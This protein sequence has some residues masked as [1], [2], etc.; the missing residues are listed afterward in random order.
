MIKQ[1][2][3]IRELIS[4]APAEVKSRAKEYRP[5]FVRSS[6]NT[7]VY[8]VGDYTV[9][10]KF[11]KIQPRLRQQLTQVQYDKLRKIKDRDT[12]VSCTCRFW[13]WNGP[14]FNAA[15]HGY[16]ERQFSDLSDPAIRDPELKYLICKHVYA[17]LLKFKHDV[18]EAE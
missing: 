7:W 2:M 15:L 3:T 4:R 8:N 12:F 9:R 17:A 5:L 10:I 18:G 11:K 16:S 6:N 14:D 1:A 13:K